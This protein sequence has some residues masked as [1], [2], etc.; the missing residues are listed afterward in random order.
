MISVFRGPH[1][2]TGKLLPV[3]IVHPVTARPLEQRTSGGVP[4]FSLNYAP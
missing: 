2:Q 1:K 4:R 3:V